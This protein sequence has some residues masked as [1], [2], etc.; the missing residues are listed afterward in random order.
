MITMAILLVA[1][2]IIS[3][4]LILTIGGTMIAFLLAFGDIIIAIWF[5][6]FIAKKLFKKKK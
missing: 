2:L 3:A 1:V 6:V 5:L 4:I